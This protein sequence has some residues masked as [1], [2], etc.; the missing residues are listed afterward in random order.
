MGGIKSCSISPMLVSLEVD[1][2]LAS[3]AHLPLD[4]GAG[5]ADQ[6]RNIL[7]NQKLLLGF[8]KSAA[9]VLSTGTPPRQLQVR[10]GGSKSKRKR[11]PDDE[12]DDGQPEEDE[13]ELGVEEDDDG[14]DGV[15]ANDDMDA[16][17]VAV[18]TPLRPAP[19]RQG[20][21]IVTLR[22]SEPYTSW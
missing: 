14:W 3:A 2:R 7:T 8:L 6:D 20:V 5:I 21:I 19:P 9:P 11:D 18:D 4:I 1:D 22:D 13:I 10:S 15:G 12:E 17:E 16:G